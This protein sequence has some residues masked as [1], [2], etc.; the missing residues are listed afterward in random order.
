MDHDLAP[1]SSGGYQVT[2]ETLTPRSADARGSGVA[3]RA[4]RQSHPLRPSGGPVQI[5]DLGSGPTTSGELPDAVET[6]LYSCNFPMYWV[7]AER[8]AEH[9]QVFLTVGLH[10][11]V[12]SDPVSQATRD[13]EE[14]LLQHPKCLAVGEVGLDYHGH[15]SPEEQRSQRHY[16]HDRLRE[17]YGKPL[18]IHC[19]SHYSAPRQAREDLLY[20]LSRHV[21]SAQPLLI[22]SFSGDEDD[23]QAWLRAFPKA[24]F[25]LGKKCPPASVVSLLP[26]DQLVL[27]SDAP[28]QCCG[29]ADLA[30]VCH[31]VAARLNLPPPCLAQLTLN[32]ARRFFRL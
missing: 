20:I 32:N 17:L 25:G 23:V 19:R 30:N 26:V 8:I 7:K 24:H 31:D 11:H 12:V 14:I 6:A 9:P 1:S 4:V 22:H 18:V 29:L 15:T 27:E 21:G 10:P 16:L 3:S 28:F 2:G 13:R 5:L